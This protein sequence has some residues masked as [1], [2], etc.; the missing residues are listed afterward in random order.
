MKKVDLY[1]FKRGL[2]SADFSHPSMT[3]AVQKNLRKVKEVITDMEAAIKHSDNFAAF[4]KA[5]E[6]LAK[7]FSEKDDS[8]NPKTKEI[9][10]G[11]GGFQRIYIIPGQDDL[12]SKYRKELTKLEKKH[13]EDIKEHTEK[14]RK[15]NDEFLLDDSEFQPFMIDLE[16]LEQYEKCPQ[17]VMNLIHWMI[18][19]PK[20]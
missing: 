5:R 7:Q 10:T 3:Y 9:S 11:D 20:E 2:E 16:V 12:T 6:E 19:E 8:G 1:S 18:R 13:E 17:S 14:V 4:V 15:Y